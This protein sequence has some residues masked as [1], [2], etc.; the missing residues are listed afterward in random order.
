[1]MKLT[2]ALKGWL[3]ANMAVAADAADAEFHKAIGDAIVQEKL[4][5]EQLKELLLEPGTK[6]ASALVSKVD[7]LTTLV[8]KLTALT[9]QSQQKAVSADP[10]DEEE[11]EDDEA[12]SKATRATRAK[13]GEG[14]SKT[15]AMLSKTE[16]RAEGSELDV[17]VKSAVEQYSTTKSQ[18]VYPEMSKHRT[19]HPL[20]GRPVIDYSGSEAGEPVD[21]IS[22]LGKALVGVWGKFEIQRSKTGSRMLAYHSLND[23]E[24]GL[25]HHLIENEKWGG[26]TNVAI[27]EG[28]WADINGRKLS[29]F[30]QKALIDDATSGGLEAAPIVFDQAIIETPL[31]YGE[32]FPLV[33]LINLDRGRRIEGVATGTV[34]MA[35]GGVDASAISLFTTTSYVSA[36]DTTIFRIQGAIQIGLDFLSDTPIDFGAH[37]AR[38]YG[39][40][41]LEELDDAIATGNGTTGPEGIMTKVGTTSINF[42]GTTSIGNYESMLSAVAVQE[43]R[44][45]YG[46]TTVFC[47]TQTS[48]YRA[49]A[50]PVGASDARRL[51][52]MNYKDRTWLEYPYKINSSLTNQQIFFAVL[53]KYRMYRRRGL[54]MRQSTEGDTLIRANSMLIS[55]TARFGGQAERGAIAAVTSTAPA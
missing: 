9:V 29:Q 19:P 16:R 14:M 18:L 51:G 5:P 4:T 37:I 48:Y 42:G 23:H 39:E 7:T 8:E 43:L 41:L 50:I 10:E 27:D 13:S 35:W 20:A 2:V 28:N 33:N 22:Q 11:D 6:E 53:G 1:M 38:Q 49:R 40:R 31:L 32:L 55:V 26:T 17:R 21:S 12:A 47:G 3:V 36:F 25:F 52:G 24:K 54:T 46:N 15:L 30:E 44:G 45:M 34:T